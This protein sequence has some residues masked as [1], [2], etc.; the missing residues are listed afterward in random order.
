MCVRTRE[1]S[2]PE[3]TDPWTRRVRR[4]DVTVVNPLSS[5]VDWV[6][7]LIHR[8]SPMTTVCQEAEE[9]GHALS[10]SATPTP[11]VVFMF[12]MFAPV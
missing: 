6:C 11:P 5:A 9:E 3:L 10:I 8:P 12:T 2:G 4:S 7:T 1:T